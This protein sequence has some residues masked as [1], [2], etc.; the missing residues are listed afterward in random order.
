MDEAISRALE[1]NHQIQSS[2]YAVRKTKWDKRQAW[3]QLLPTVR[4]NSRYSWIDDSTYALRDFSRYFNNSNS[5]FQ[6]PQTVFQESYASSLDVTMPVFNAG[7]FNGIAIAEANSELQRLVQKSVRNKTVFQ[8]IHTYLSVLKNNEVLHLQEQYLEL[9]R[10]N[11]EKAQRLYNAGRYSQTEALRWKMDYQQQKSIVASSKSNLRNSK[12]LLIRLTNL[13]FEHDCLFDSRIPPNLLSESKKMENLTERE[14]L[15]TFRMKDQDLIK[16]NPALS[17]NQS[18]VRF[19]KLQYRQSLTSHLPTVSMSYSYGWREN[20]TFE[21]DDYSPQTFM[22][23]LS[24]PLFS[25]FQDFTKNKSTHYQFKQQ[26][27]EFLDQLQNT[28]YLLAETA[29]KMINL[30]TQLNHS[31]TNVQYSKRNYQIVKQQKEKGLISNIEFI[32]AKLNW[33]NAQLLDISN[34]YDFITAIVELYYLLDRLDELV[35]LN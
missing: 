28:R 32:D 7:I 34:R 30:K 8:V 5:P 11:Y 20:S 3:A 27:E 12:T 21:L 22:I 6:V 19:K 15:Q 9:S 16:R 1:K 31:K 14:I 25:G 35:H 10:L 33:Q 26:Q 24:L 2:R 23:N 17:A 13:S 4:L 29:N 18:S